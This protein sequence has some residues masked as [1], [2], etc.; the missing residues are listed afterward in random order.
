MPAV[1][2]SWADHTALLNAVDTHVGADGDGLLTRFRTLL[3]GAFVQPT[4][5][6]MEEDHL[7]DAE[8]PR[9]QSLV[10]PTRCALNTVLP[11]RFADLARWL[12]TLVAEVTEPMEKVDTALQLTRTCVSRGYTPPCWT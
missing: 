10:Q 9:M 2:M 6:A 12:Y 1:N 4:V 5:F 8:L 11:R 7:L 3:Q